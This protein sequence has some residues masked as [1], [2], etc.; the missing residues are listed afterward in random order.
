MNP[1]N[2]SAVQLA[3]AYIHLERYSDAEEVLT[4]QENFR[5]SKQ[6]QGLLGM[7]Y[8]LRQDYDSA[9]KALEY[10]LIDNSG[11]VGTSELLFALLV[12]KAQ[13]AL[14]DNNHSQV[15]DILNSAIRVM[16]DDNRFKK[17]LSHFENV[18]PISHLKGGERQ[19]AADLWIQKIVPG[20]PVTNVIH[21]LALLFYYWAIA[22]EN[23]ILDRSASDIEQN[24][25]QANYLWS[26]AFMY[27]NSFIYSP[28]FWE[29]QC[30]EKSAVWGCSVSQEEVKGIRNGI[31]ESLFVK[32][33]ED[34]IEKYRGNSQEDATRIKNYLIEFQ[35][36]KQTSR[37]FQEILDIIGRNEEYFNSDLQNDVHE[38]LTL[39]EPYTLSFIKQ[40]F[41]KQRLT[42][43]IISITSVRLKSD[44]ENQVFESMRIACKFPTFSKIIVSINEFKDFDTATYLWEK[45]LKKEGVT[46][47]AS[48]MKT[49]EAQY[50][51]ALMSYTKGCQLKSN[52]D[53]N[54][55]LQEWQ[56]SFQLLSPGGRKMSEENFP[57]LIAVLKQQLK[58]T[59]GAECVK[60]AKVLN[61]A[62]KIDEAI[63]ILVK[64]LEMSANDSIRDLLCS[65]Y[66]EKALKFLKDN[67]FSLANSL[68]QQ[69]LKLNKGYKTALTGLSN[70]KN[71]EGMAELNKGNSD[72]GIKLLEEALELDKRDVV[73]KN[74]AGALNSQAVDIINAL[75]QYSSSSSCDRAISLLAR[76]I[77]LLN[78]KLD[79]TSLML[80]F[81]FT[82]EYSFNNMVK[83]I[84]DGLY[85]TML[86]NFWIATRTR[87]NLRGY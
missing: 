1:A 14:K 34:Y 31:S 47:S 51:R 20:S 76:G 84:N 45:L 58:E 15:T 24:R 30:R 21:N 13:Q 36:E 9:I 35:F 69:A 80:T 22:A 70:S 16:P 32:V 53:I 46:A 43:K 27:W 64:G 49:A 65:N 83:D 85:K 11:K 48:I 56:G 18:L 62:G 40:H 72:K 3:V 66:C 38:I 67:N 23:K 10:Q 25:T 42:E 7:V 74:L 39:K 19:K 50:V 6:L 5:T 68:F 77:E 26:K 63:D 82:D 54:Q 87:R 12:N 79:E 41:A 4:R 44:A 61:S 86:R 17:Y 8:A 57:A 78:D 75:N 29:R 52:G 37:Y 60:A 73:A 2:I 59:V 28:S 33:L 55:A 71:N 81:A